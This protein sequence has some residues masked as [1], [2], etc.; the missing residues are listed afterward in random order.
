MK[1]NEKTLKKYIRQLIL[2]EENIQ[3]MSLKDV[4]DKLGNIEEEIANDLHV[5]VGEIDDHLTDSHHLYDEYMKLK[6]RFQEL[7]ESESKSQSVDNTKKDFYFDASGKRVDTGT[8]GRGD[9]GNAPGYQIRENKKVS[10]K[11]VLKE[12]F[13]QEE[14]LQKAN[15]VFLIGPPAVGK[16]EYIKNNLQ[17][18]EIVNRD[19]LVTQAAE[20]SG[21]GTY[22]DMY[23]RPPEELKDQAGP[24]PEK[25]VVSAYETDPNAKEQVDQYLEKIKNIAVQVPENPKY[26]QIKPFDLESL[27][28]V[29][30]K[31]GVPTKFINPFVWEKV[32][33]ANKA[34]GEK[35][36]DVRSKAV[37]SKNEKRKNMAIDMVS[38]SINERNMHRKDILKALG[39]DLNDL[40]SVNKYYNQIAV[41][42]APESGY[43]P[44]LIDQIKQVA[45]LRQQEIAARGGSKTIPPAAYDRMFASYNPPTTEEGFSE[46][47]YVGVPSLAKLGNAT[48]EASPSSIQEGFTPARWQKIAGIIKD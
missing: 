43:T 31:F 25:D 6:K 23:A 22:D 20:E 39:E 4:G 26:G 7:E 17:G 47:K 14:G 30:V 3:D 10:L 33:A 15:L 37:G 1:L 29:V 41:V 5:S 36:A 21:V 9:L 32:D 24:P 28:T 40:A 46:I 44:E 38:M 27:K 35:L 11:S 2:E 45:V 13:E 42:F 12:M 34:V 18:Y 16:T 19:D 48:N 8:T